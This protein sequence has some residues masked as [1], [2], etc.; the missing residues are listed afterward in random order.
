MIE[1]V[2]YSLLSWGPT[3]IQQTSPVLASQPILLHIARYEPETWLHVLHARLLD[4][5]SV[6]Y[7]AAAQ[8]P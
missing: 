8:T 3:D 7:N 6:C 4:A 5:M 1:G 2:V